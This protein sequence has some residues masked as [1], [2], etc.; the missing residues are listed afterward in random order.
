MQ[1]NR[2]AGF[3]EQQEMEQGTWGLLY[4]LR[5]AG[6]LWIAQYRV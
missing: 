3:A 4:R 5:D 1:S 2:S 6:C